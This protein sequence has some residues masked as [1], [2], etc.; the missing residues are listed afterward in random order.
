MRKVAS[1]KICVL[2]GRS[3]GKTSLLSSL[4]A[5]SGTKESGISALG[6]NQRKLAIYNDYKNGHGKLSATSWEDICQFRYKI[7]GSENKR[8]EVSFIDYPGE[9]F[10]KFFE[11]EN[12][13]ILNGVLTKLKTSGDA[14]KTKQEDLSYGGETKKAKRIFKEILS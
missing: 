4:I 7:T 1:L 10:Q 14:G 13:G 2:G 3:F 5:I 11:D 9:F 6:D 8:W 12:S